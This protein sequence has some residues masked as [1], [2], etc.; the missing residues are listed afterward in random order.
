[1]VVVG[2]CGIVGKVAAKIET[3]ADAELYPTLFLA[4]TL[5]L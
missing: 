5:N 3:G 2:A 4:S 1:M